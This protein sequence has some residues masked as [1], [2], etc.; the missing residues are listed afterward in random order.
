M[1]RGFCCIFVTHGVRIG[2]HNPLVPSSTLGGPTS[3]SMGLT[4]SIFMRSLQLER[5]LAPAP[6]PPRIGSWA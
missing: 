5:S 6:L 2:S 4:A 3:R 1:P